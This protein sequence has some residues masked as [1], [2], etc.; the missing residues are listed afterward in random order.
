MGNKKEKNK[1]TKDYTCLSGYKNGVPPT[2]NQQ[3]NQQVTV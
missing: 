2:W 1:K 3:T